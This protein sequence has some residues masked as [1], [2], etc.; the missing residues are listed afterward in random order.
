MGLVFWMTVMHIDIERVYE[1]VSQF[2]V[3]SLGVS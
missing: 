1:S 2:I 3:T